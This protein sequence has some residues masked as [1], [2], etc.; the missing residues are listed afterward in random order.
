MDTLINDKLA[1]L[2]AETL[3]IP[4]GAIEDDLD[5]ENTGTWDSLSHMQLIAAIEDEFAIEL[6]SDEIVTMRSLK[7]IRIVLRAHDVLG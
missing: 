2:I 7:Q 3:R 5:M 1:T 6:T 4:G